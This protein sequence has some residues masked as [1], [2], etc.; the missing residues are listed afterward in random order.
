MQAGMTLEEVRVLHLHPK[1][2]KNKLTFKQLGGRTLKA[3][4][5]SDTLSP[6][7]PH[8]LLVPLPR[9]SKST[10]PS[11]SSLWAPPLRC[12]SAVSLFLASIYLCIYL[13]IC[14]LSIYTHTHTHTYTH[15]HTLLT[16]FL[17]FFRTGLTNFLAVSLSPLHSPPCSQSAC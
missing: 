13:F 8:L 9:P 5:H 14:N 7:R 3:H 17:G 11:T 2:A 15:T 4:S 6:T 1:E 10:Y 16:C 12:T